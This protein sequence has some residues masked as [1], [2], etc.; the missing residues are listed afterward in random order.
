M[1]ICRRQF[2]ACLLGA[3]AGKAWGIPGRPKL[4]VLVIVEQLRPDALEAAESQFSA[5]GFRRLAE[6]GAW[7]NNCRH[8]SSTFSSTGL[9]NLA[10]G[11]WPAQHG[12]IA[13]NWYDRATHQPIA[14]SEE[15]LLATTLAAQAAGEERFRIMVIGPTRDEAALFAGTNAAQLWYFDDRCDYTVAGSPPDWLREFNAGKGAEG[16][17]DAD[18]MAINAAKEA[19]PLRTLKY[20]L[21]H[22]QQFRALYK[23]SPFAQRATYELAAQLVTE[24]NLGKEA[25]SDFLCVIDGST[26]QLGYETGGRD[27]LMNQLILNLDL[28]IDALLSHLT[29]VVGENQFNLVVCA[30]HG[31]PLAPSKDTRARLAVNS[32]ELA[33]AL[34]NSLDDADRHVEKYVYPFLYL[35][36]EGGDRAEALH[37]V[38]RAA[39][40]QPAVAGYYTIN[41]E[42]SLNDVWRRRFENSFHAK[43]SGDLMLSYRPEYIEGFRS[44]SGISYGSLY[45]Y[46][47]QTPLIFYGP[48][49]KPARMEAAVDAVDV[50]PTLAYLMGL[51]QPSSSVG[52]VLTEAFAS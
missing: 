6:K 10:T 17:R 11:A 30:A 37:R 24:N 35:D 14:A 23:G 15:L 31:A 49:I 46:D 4:T 20:D 25:T 5:G 51:G 38:A 22:P 44:D 21:N 36:R 7:F 41:G 2:G 43:R 13:D 52:R 18:W 34:Q 12:I 47:V 16:A 50:A 40:S 8:L 45:N 48:G 42:C 1:D 39:L 33:Q 26:N 27:R 32:E 9:A 29:K 19:P 3:M 28:R